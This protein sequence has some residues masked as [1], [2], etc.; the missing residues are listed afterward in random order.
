[1]PSLDET[2]AIC[3]GK[4]FSPH[5]PR[6]LYLWD[7]SSVRIWVN[8]LIQEIKT[9]ALWSQPGKEKTAEGKQEVNWAGTNGLLCWLE[10]ARRPPPEKIIN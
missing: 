7:H 8:G 5:L 6:S 9:E 4:S 10:E 3:L 2:T 1:M